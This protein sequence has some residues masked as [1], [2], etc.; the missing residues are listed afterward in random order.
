[1][2]DV[3]DMYEMGLT[4]EHGGL[5]DERAW[6]SPDSNKNG[7]YK[8]NRYIKSNAVRKSGPGSRWTENDRTSLMDMYQNDVSIRVIAKKLDRT[9]YAIAFQLHKR[10]LIP[11]VVKDKFKNDKHFDAS[12]GSID[13][14]EK[15]K[16]LI[17]KEYNNDVSIKEIAR[18]VGRNSHSVAIELSNSKILTSRES[19]K[20]SKNS[21]YDSN[22]SDFE[23]RERIRKAKQQQN[24]RVR[25]ENKK[26]AQ[27]KEDAN[28]MWG[29]IIAITV[30]IVWFVFG[31]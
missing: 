30:A 3:D 5:L 9:P 31:A 27:R 21:D 25:E 17:C 18:R 2:G 14:T 28:Y 23:D 29:V 6:G 13:F 7:P 16:R 11:A 15:E 8:K 10:S 12:I 20:F 24:R 19:D 1:M 4:K 26:K 22:R